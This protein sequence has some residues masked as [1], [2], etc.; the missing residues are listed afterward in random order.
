MVVPTHHKG[1]LT[2]VN[3]ESMRDHIAQVSSRAPRRE[4][5]TPDTPTLAGHT[6]RTRPAGY[7]MSYN[8]DIVAPRPVLVGVRRDRHGKLIYKV[9]YE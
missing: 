5:G 8:P 9:R 1:G 6:T 3:P 4:T 7:Q 2:Y